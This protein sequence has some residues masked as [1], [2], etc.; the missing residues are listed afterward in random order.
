[1]S[2]TIVITGA[3]SGLGKHLAQRFAADGE[4]VV[5][6]GRTLSKLEAVAENLGD[7]AMAIACDVGS[8]DAVRAAFDRIAERHPRI[9]V[10]INNAM[11]TEIGTLASRTTRQIEDVLGTNLVGA[12]LC[13]HAALLMMDRGAHIISV[14]SESLETPFPRHVAYQASKA[15]LERMSHFL[16]QELAPRGIRVT[17]VRAGEMVEKGGW[18]FPPGFTLPPDV[19]EFFQAAKDAGLDLE[20]R[21]KSDYASCTGIFR[22]IID[23][24]PDVQI[25][26]VHFIA[27]QTD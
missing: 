23:Q 16:Q 14:S 19:A 20:K 13:I 12:M 6:L 27:R 24:P 4:Q 10:L 18:D 11:L 7:R 5:L 15:G 21:P 17:I 1:M 2:K 8:A 22:A 26:T 9:D 3:G 25:T